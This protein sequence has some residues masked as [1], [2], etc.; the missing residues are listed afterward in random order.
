MRILRAIRDVM[1]WLPLPGLA[2]LFG[3][4]TDWFTVFPGWNVTLLF[5][6]LFAG[7]LAWILIV[8][9]VR[10]VEQFQ[11]AYPGFRAYK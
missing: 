6:L 4:V 8:R 1:E 11:K 9:G 7:N 5:A 10:R 3:F 2:L